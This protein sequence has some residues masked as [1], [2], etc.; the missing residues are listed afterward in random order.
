[1]TSTPELEQ[2]PAET[3]PAPAEPVSVIEKLIT[4][5]IAEAAENL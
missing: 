1:M 4:D 3:P 2:Q 5:C